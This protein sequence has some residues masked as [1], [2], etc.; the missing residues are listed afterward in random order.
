[1][2]ELT[3]FILAARQAN[4]TNEEIIS[5]LKEKGWQDDLIYAAVVEA[6]AQTPVVT[7]PPVVQ[8]EVVQEPIVQDQPISSFA[9]PSEVFIPQPF[10]LEKGLEPKNP[11][12]AESGEGCGDSMTKCFERS[13]CAPFCRA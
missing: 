7:P 2:N 5:S 8:E 11:R 4:E 10:V 6:D 9:V 12:W 13:I 1:M 3:E